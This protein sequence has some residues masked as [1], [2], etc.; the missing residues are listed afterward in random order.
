MQL[1]PIRLLTGVLA[2]PLMV[3]VL[4]ASAGACG[5]VTGLSNDYVF[6][7]QEDG[8]GVTGDAKADTAANADGA[9]TD[10]TTDAPVTPV[11][12]ATCS[13]TQAATIEQRL[14]QFNGSTECKTCLSND[15]CTDVDSCLNIT[16]C[17]KAFE[18]RLDCTTM[19]GTDRHSCFQTCDSNSGGNVTP[20]SYT[21]GVGACATSKCSAA[22]ACA[23]L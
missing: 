11:D 1:T 4:A 9:K 12:A 3:V 6:D 14:T 18:C 16:E 2:M 8:G 5:Q 17:R 22:T 23:F 10:G 21:S 13:S 15:C 7:L 20:M 19:S